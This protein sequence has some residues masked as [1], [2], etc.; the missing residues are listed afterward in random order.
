MLKKKAAI[1]KET[2]ESLV[3]CIMR[4]NYQVEP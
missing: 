2:A 4:L 3:L 1:Q